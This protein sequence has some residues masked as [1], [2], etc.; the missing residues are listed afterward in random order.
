MCFL[1]NVQQCPHR[2]RQRPA[3][4]T[5]SGDLT[6]TY[7]LSPFLDKNDAIRVGGRLDNAE[8]IPESQRNR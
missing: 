4:L 1:L 7:K 2:H 8:C 5:S 3:A 6:T